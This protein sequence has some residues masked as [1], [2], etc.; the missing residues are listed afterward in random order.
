MPATSLVDARAFRLGFAT[1]TVILGGQ[2]LASINA[3]TLP[4]VVGIIIIGVC[5]LIPCFIGYD[6]VHV[7]ERYAW[8]VT[9]F[10]MCCLY[11]LGGKA[12]YDANTQK[13]LEGTGKALTA[14]IFGFGAMIFG[15]VAGW[16]P[17][18]ADY[19]VRL[20]VETNS[21]RVFMLTFWGLYL[22]IVF[23][24]TLGAALMTITDPGYVAAFGSSGDTGALIAQVLSPWGGGGKILL[25][26]L[27]LS[28]M[29]VSFLLTE[30][31]TYV[32][33]KK[34]QQHSQYIFCSSLHT[35]ARS[36]VCH[37]TPFPLGV[38]RVYCVYRCRCC[39]TGAF[40]C[41]PQRPFVHIELLDS[42]LPRHHRGGAFPISAEMGS[43]GR[44]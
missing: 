15:S 18:A 32:S 29:C 4:L 26:M 7:Y 9:F 37:G 16:A 34:F 14:D 44:I 19:N 28:A 36:T 21:W 17:V 11:G 10:V 42:I 30:C 20:P 41:Y 13:P 22:P 6:M 27:A 12:G 39:W 23:T 43:V 3:N 31:C 24:M 5:C 40:Q 1:V 25:V 35:S 38:L 8:M 33:T 2:T